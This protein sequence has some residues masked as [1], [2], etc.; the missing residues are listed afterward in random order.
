ME[1]RMRG[2]ICPALAGM[3]GIMP[4][5]SASERTRATLLKLRSM[6]RRLMGCP[7]TLMFHTTGP[8]SLFQ[9]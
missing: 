7:S 8:T 2:A 3:S 4:G 5:R 9:Q 6:M 1:W